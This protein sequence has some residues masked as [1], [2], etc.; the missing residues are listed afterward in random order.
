MYT[1]KCH[2]L[3]GRGQAPGV[4]RDKFQ[5]RTW[6]VPGS[7]STRPRL[8][9]GDLHARAPRARARQL[10]GSSLTISRP[11]RDLPPGLNLKDV[12][13]PKA[14]SP[15]TPDPRSGVQTGNGPVLI[16]HCNPRTRVRIPRSTGAGCC[17]IVVLAL[18]VSSTTKTLILLKSIKTNFSEESPIDFA[19]SA[20]GV[21]FA[22]SQEG[23]VRLRN[24]DP[25]AG[26]G[27]KF[28]LLLAEH[29]AL[30]FTT[31]DTP[32]AKTRI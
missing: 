1:C 5:A 13:H 3:V 25:C 17:K 27:S 22:F 32:A 28:I 6:Q 19:N 18:G 29:G 11:E 8:E 9:S 7:D 14:G 4:E 24:Y 30:D 2:A 10:A 15:S 23:C 12:Y 16:D 21:E 20:V 31:C 26:R